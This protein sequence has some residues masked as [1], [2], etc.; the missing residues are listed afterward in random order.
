MLK[1]KG[2][3]LKSGI[4]QSPMANCT[5]LPF[6]LVAREKGM[7][8][9]FL[10]MISAEALLYDTKTT[11]EI[12]K[13]VPEDRPLGAQLVGCHPDKMAEAGA[14]L[15]GMG[16]DWIDINLGCPVPKVTGKGGGSSLLR[17]PEVAREIFQKMTQTVRKIP[18][19]VKMRKGYSDESGGEAVLIAQYAEEAGLD[20]VTVH[21]RTREQGYSGHADYEAI[22]KVKQ[23][24]SI[25]VIGNG[26]VVDAASAERLRAVSGCDAVMIGRGGL[27]NPWIYREIEKTANGGIL[28]A[29]PSLEEIKSTLIRHMELEVQ[30]EGR[31]ALF[32]M[33]RIACWYFRERPGVSE[34]RE[35]INHSQ[36]L[37]EVRRLIE[38]FE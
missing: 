11:R 35:K 2:F 38:N 26:D 12:L 22:R 21:G 1:L 28:P 29:S 7:E 14:V 15:E 37:E 8:F 24:V 30:Y 9:A 19:T 36:T 6:R 27:G 17:E 18:L 20:A 13:T 3:E 25:P 31:T 34:F 5:D 16:F 10:E 32:R 33:R 4:L 23:A